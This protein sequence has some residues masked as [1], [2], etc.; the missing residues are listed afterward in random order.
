MGAE[1]TC[2]SIA[3][4]R[5]WVPDTVG[6]VHQ[7]WLSVIVLIAQAHLDTDTSVDSSGRLQG[8]RMPSSRPPAGAL[9]DFQELGPL[10]EGSCARARGALPRAGGRGRG[11]E[12]FC[13]PYSRVF[14]KAFWVITYFFG[15]VRV[16]LAVQV[17]TR[18]TGVLVLRCSF[19][20]AVT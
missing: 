16:F 17:F 8:A 4:L 11:V 12:V 7:A 1:R 2:H 18:N 6:D 15:C 19:V 13:A 20:C 9:R 10:G 5:G 14:L 3:P